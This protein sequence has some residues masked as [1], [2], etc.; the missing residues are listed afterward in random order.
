MAKITKEQI[1]K[2]NS[3]CHNGW[4]LDT[5]YYLFH[6]EKILFK[7]IEIDEENYLRY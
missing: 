7:N 5:Q 3:Q 6:G 1:M 2:V 4:R